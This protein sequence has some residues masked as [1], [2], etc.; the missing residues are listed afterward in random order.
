MKP[1]RVIIPL[2][3]ILFLFSTCSTDTQDT[4]EEI[5]IL[6]TND[7]HGSINNYARIAS[8]VA[9][10]KQ[11]HENVYLVSGGDIFSGNPV[12]DQ[13]PDK[14]YPMID[15]MNIVGYNLAV[16]GNHE[17]DYGQTTLNARMAQASFP[18]LCANMGTSGAVLNQPAA[19]ATLTTKGGHKLTFLGVVQVGSGGIPATHPYN[20]TNIVFSNPF[21]TAQNYAHLKNS[22]H[23]LI[24]LSHLGQSGDISLAG[25]MPELD[26]IIG[27]H[28]HSWISSGAWEDGVLITQAGGNLYGLGKISIRMENGIVTE[29]NAEI[30][31][32]SSITTADSSVQATINSYN[33]NPALTEVIGHTAVSISGK[34]NLGAFMTDAITNQTA[35][36]IAFQNSGGIRISS[37]GPGY[38]TPGDIYSLDPFHNEVILY[39]MNTNEIASLLRGTSGTDLKAAGLYYTVSGSSVT[40]TDKSGTP[41]TDR[42]YT[43]ALSSY[44]ASAY[45][46]SC[47][48]PGTGIGT[49]SYDVIIN[50]VRQLSNI[51]HPVR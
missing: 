36:E 31:D 34:D 19:H 25:Q 35:A 42:Y 1:K 26:L 33:N 22:A 28:S 4:I 30:I 16:I 44:V 8:I 6:H 39:Q 5:I 32:L 3:L 41:L 10:L 49:N 12:V 17:F 43:V 24:L 51:P 21:T 20:A 40:I 23:M 2:L 50:Y 14:G 9:T 27:G 7:T 11:Q 13:Y 29:K 45:T 48:D 15:L 47:T 37:L 18:F 46:F 38:I